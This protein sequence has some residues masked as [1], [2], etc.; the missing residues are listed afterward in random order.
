MTYD[1]ATGTRSHYLNG[2]LVGT[3]ADVGPL[4]TNTDPL[5]I[6]SDPAFGPEPE[7]ALDEFRLWNVARTQGEIQST[8]D[9]AISTPMP[10]LVAVW[11]LDSDGSD[12]LGTYNGTIVGNPVF[13][14][15]VPALPA[16]ALPVLLLLLAA[17]AVWTLTRGRARPIQPV[18]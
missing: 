11:P 10:G 14:T 16:G 12:A 2:V 6:G 5:R 3:R 9:T 1:S 4:T 18:Q 8:M 7:A 17:V 13:T 15:A